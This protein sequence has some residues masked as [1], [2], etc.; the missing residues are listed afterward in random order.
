MVCLLCLPLPV[1]AQPWAGSGTAEDPYQLWD[2]NDI[3][4]VGADPNFWDA[5][6]KLRSDLDMSGYIGTAYNIIGNSAVAFTGVFDGNGHTIRNLTYYAASK[7]DVGLFGVVDDPGAIIKNVQLIDPNIDAG[8]GNDV[9]ALIGCIESGTVVKCGVKGGSVSGDHSVG[10]LVGWA[11]NAKVSYCSTETIVTGRGFFTGGLIANIAHGQMSDNYSV[12][13]ITGPSY[14]GGLIG[15]FCSGGFIHN[16][17]SAASVSATEYV[18]AFVGRHW[19]NGTYRKCFWD[20]AINPSLNGIGNIDDPNVVG[21][22]TTV[23]QQM[24]TFTDAG[25]DFIGED[26]NGTDDIWDICEETNYP[27]LVW[28]ILRADFVCPYGVT[29]PD[30]SVLAAAWMSE[31]NHLK[32]KAACDISEPND[33][34]VDEK[35]LAVFVQD[36]LTGR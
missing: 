12:S 33:G 5:H 28:E 19:D 7:D 4:A 18:G 21:H 2:A 13:T 27:R 24:A 22:P 32:W 25:W 35:D 31:P 23:M 34:I 10:G 16:C 36:W 29:M 9:G 30:F 20:S 1:S 3:Q 8:W 6:F 11:V 26:I 17:Y 15:L 14:V